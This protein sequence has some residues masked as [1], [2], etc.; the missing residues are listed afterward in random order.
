[1][2]TIITADGKGVGGGGK[3]GVA[4][5]TVADAAA[6]GGVRGGGGKEFAWTSW[7]GAVT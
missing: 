7:I 2:G 4:H 6:E 3:S 5:V 1:M